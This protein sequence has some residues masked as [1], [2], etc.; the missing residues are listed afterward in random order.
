MNEEDSRLRAV[1]DRAAAGVTL[2]LE[3]CF[4]GQS[5]LRFLEHILNEDGVS[6]DREKTRAFSKMPPPANVSDL[7]SLLGRVNQL[8][9]FSP[10]LFGLTQ[11]LGELLKPHNSCLRKHFTNLKASSSWSYLNLPFWLFL[12]YKQK[13]KSLQIAHPTG[14]EW[15]SSRSNHK[16]NGDLLLMRQEHLLMW[17]VDMRRLR[18]R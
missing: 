11:Q 16:K 7:K 6:A 12:N 4:F 14:W 3:T 5:E 13:Q 18:R 15:S 9:R 10:N 2:N 8:G 1:V 17:N